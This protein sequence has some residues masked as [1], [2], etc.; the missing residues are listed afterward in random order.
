MQKTRRRTAFFAAAASAAASDSPLSFADRVASIP[1]MALDIM[2]GRYDGTSRGRLLVM[3]AAALYIVSPIDLLPEAFLTLPGLADDAVVA[4]WLVA[5]LFG[6]TTAYAAWRESRI[7]RP[8]SGGRVVPGE[9][10]R[11]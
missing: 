3:V 4:G 6:A 1:R 2:L 7:P 5:S 11:S 10:I 9:V 8:A